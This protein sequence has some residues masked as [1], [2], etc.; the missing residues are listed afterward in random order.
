MHRAARG[1]PQRAYVCSIAVEKSTR[2]LTGIYL[3]TPAFV[4]DTLATVASKSY[5]PGATPAQNVATSPMGLGVPR[6]P[7]AGSYGQAGVGGFNTAQNGLQSRKRGYSDRGEDSK[8]GRDSHYGRNAGG[9]RA[10]K[11]PRRGG[12]RGGMF[13][14]FG[15]RVGGR[16][17]MGRGKDVNKAHGSA[18]MSQSP[19]VGF[20]GMP[21]TPPGFPFDPANSMPAIMAMQAMGFPPLPGMPP[22]P[23][24]GSPTGFGQPRIGQGSP[25]VG[26]SRKVAKIRERCKDYDQK[27]FCALGSTCP[28]EHGTDHIIVPTD[29][30]GKTKSQDTEKMVA[31]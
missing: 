29:G 25:P 8:D 12:A 26:G 1:F 6:G 24:P 17:E 2:A 16:P 20:P 3:D 22:F 23:Q 13:D 4:D 10:I 15:N 9:E 7:A 31:N 5:V 21:P 14:S 19:P 18:G 27:G 28:Y 11:Q 30:D